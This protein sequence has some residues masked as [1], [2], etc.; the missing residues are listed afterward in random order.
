MKQAVIM[1]ICI[2]ILLGGGIGEIKFLDKSSI[3]ILSEIDY[4]ENAINNSNFDEANK[5]IEITFDNW[6]QIKNLWNIFIIHE[7]IDDIDE[8]IIEL[9]EYVK[10]ENEEECFVAIEKIKRDLEH[11]VKRQKVL[12]DNIL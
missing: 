8:A 4:I 1:I 10:F 6:T 11:T 3:Y 9:R 5:Q 7:E 12:L 2:L